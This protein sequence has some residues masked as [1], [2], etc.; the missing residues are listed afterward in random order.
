MEKLRIRELR[1]I[2]SAAQRPCRER[3]LAAGQ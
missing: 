2:G 1:E 3:S